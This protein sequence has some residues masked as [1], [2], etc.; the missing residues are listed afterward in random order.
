MVPRSTLVYLTDFLPMFIRNTAIITA[1]IFFEELSVL[2]Q[3][4][5][6]WLLLTVCYLL[7]SVGLSFV[8]Q[9]VLYSDA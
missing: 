2:T 7:L 5:C 1:G 8:V 3:E 4:N 9:S 6:Y